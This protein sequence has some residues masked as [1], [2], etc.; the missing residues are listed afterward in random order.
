MV[1]DVVRGVRGGELLDLGLGQVLD[2]LVHVLYWDL[3]WG[4]V[5]HGV[6]Y[7]LDHWG[8]LDQFLCRSRYNSSLEDNRR[9]GFGVVLDHGDGVEDRVG[10]VLQHWG[11]LH[12]CVCGDRG[13]L[14]PHSDRSHGMRVDLWSGHKPGH[15]VGHWDGH[16]LP[17]RI[18]ETVLVN[19][20]RESLESKG[21]ET[22][23]CLDSVTECRG[24]WARGQTGVDVV[25][26]HSQAAH[27]QGG[28]NLRGE[29]DGVMERWSDRV[30]GPSAPY[31]YLSSS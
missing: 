3:H 1:D 6:G 4:A 30:W 26:R 5:E 18:H 2:L 8:C 27:Y 28:E 15:C 17:D 9:D 22:L 29:D 24:E 16:C 19:V 21:A 10:G 31:K 13:H 14:S 23:G 25:E 12:H 20:L 11:L 7:I